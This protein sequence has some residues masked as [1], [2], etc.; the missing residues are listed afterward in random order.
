LAETTK[1]N[2]Y[3]LAQQDVAHPTLARYAQIGRLLPS[4]QAGWTDDQAIQALVE[5]L[6]DWQ[7]RFD[8]P[9]LSTFGMASDDV[10]A[11]VANS[12]GNSMKTN[13]VVLSDAQL[14]EI[15]LACL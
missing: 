10:P 7:K 2:L 4:A 1:M 11:I 14:S 3:A 5:L 13:P 6:F 15:L 9:S 8:L 12:R